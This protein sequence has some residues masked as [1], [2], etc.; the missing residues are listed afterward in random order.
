LR[1]STMTR[2]LTVLMLLGSL[3]LA[4][5][6]GRIA[7]ARL[8]RDGARP[9]QL[10]GTVILTPGTM[11]SEPDS[12]YIQDNT[13][14]I[15]VHSPVHIELT[16]RDIVEV[17]GTVHR[18]L[19]DE[20]ELFAGTITK[21]GTGFKAQPKD[22][23]VQQALLPDAAGRLV[24]VAGMVAK[25]SIG[26][27][28][29]D[30][31]IQQGMRTL[32]AYLRHSDTAASVVPTRAPVGAMVEAVGVLMPS[33]GEIHMLRIR[34]TLDL[35]LVRPPGVI[36]SRE[37]L[38]GLGVLAGIFLLAS[39]WIYSLRRSIREQ[40]GEIRGLLV[41]AEEASRVKSEFLANLSHEIRTPI[42]GIQG[43]HTLLLDSSLSAEQREELRIAQNATKH[44]LSL[45]DEVLD[46]SRIE[47]GKMSLETLPFA[48]VEVV[49]D[50]MQT[51]LPKARQKGLTM[52][53]QE[54]NLPPLVAGDAM[55]LR[56]IIFNLVSNAV[57]FTEAGRIEV[58][59]GLVDQ[60]ADDVRI[61]FRVSDT[62]IGIPV[63][64]QA[65]IFESFRQVD[66]TI[67][68]RFGGTGLGLAIA[69][70]LVRQ[71]GGELQVQSTRGSGSI[72]EFTARFAKAEDAAQ[73]GP[74]SVP[75]TAAVT[76]AQ[77]ALRILVAEDNPVNQF[78]VRRLLEQDGHELTIVAD[79]GAAIA[80]W[81]EAAYD[82][83]LMDIQMPGTDGL[84]AA[85]AIRERE[86][87]TGAA[88]TPIYAL[89]AHSMKGDRDRCSLAG[90]DGC[91]TKPF[92]PADLRRILAGVSRP[93]RGSTVS[94]GNEGAAVRTALQATPEPMEVPAKLA[95]HQ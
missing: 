80:A 72:F 36:G 14:G 83:I 73:R 70:R 28:R 58:Y 82:V 30:V 37:L 1:A 17:R 24:R 57:K 84:Q 15:S 18:I 22:L 46:L 49:R 29:D 63:E 61:A 94:T 38:T 51:F 21:V 64:Q 5:G 27:V 48:A 62:G 19:D 10:R 32:R 59:A 55:R 76:A 81:A 88:R 43:M 34:D 9:W 39:A 13:G 95:E 31:Y 90:M 65:A 71:M 3:P 68:R 56:Q 89:T 75:D 16:Y 92:S 67:S 44:L 40:T 78:L 66:G 6:E 42:H 12:F 52:T 23:T 50:A 53:S 2:L 54:V 79:G 60:G 11:P 20:P 74:T 91:L 45:L 47:A 93:P 85:A 33:D 26:S 86:A 25:N 41:K 35:T 8:T 7:D 69:L 4:G 77:P 87:V